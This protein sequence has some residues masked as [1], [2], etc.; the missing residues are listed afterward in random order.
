[1]LRGELGFDGVVMTDDLIM[2]A[3]TRYTDGA[4]AA[5]RAVQAGNDMLIS[6]DF[7]TQFEAVRAA[8][9]SGQISAD[10]IRAAALRVIRWKMALSLL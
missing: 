8:V 6:S 2:D 5:V 3:I 10:T 1:M 7:L 9:A 4:D